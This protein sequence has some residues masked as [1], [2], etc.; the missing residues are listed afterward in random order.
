MNAPFA[1]SLLAIAALCLSLV[2]FPISAPADEPANQ[3]QLRMILE[4]LSGNPV[5]QAAVKQASD[6][7]EQCNFPLISATKPPAFEDGTAFDFKEVTRCFSR[8]AGREITVT[9]KAFNCRQH[10]PLIDPVTIEI[11]RFD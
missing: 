2:A 11:S 8:G 3:I 10:C 5:V 6:A 4:A 7:D 1:A 9:G